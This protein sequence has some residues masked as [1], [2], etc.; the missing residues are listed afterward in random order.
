MRRRNPWLERAQTTV[1]TLTN[2]KIIYTVADDTHSITVTLNLTPVPTWTI[3][4]A[5][6]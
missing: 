1:T 6:L 2:T 4:G 3:D 5:A